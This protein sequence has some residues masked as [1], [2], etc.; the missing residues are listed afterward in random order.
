MK[1]LLETNGF[2]PVT[3]RDGKEGI[4]I[5]KEISPDLIIMDVMMPREG[6]ALMYQH[7]RGEKQLKDT[8]AIILSAVSR[9]S[10]FHYLNMLNTQSKQ[11]LTMPDAYIEKP[12]EPAHLL[13]TIQRLLDLE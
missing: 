5:A 10:F 12:P 9:R 3:A 8:P 6:G 13:I 4:R 7:M 1:T 11:T 2:K